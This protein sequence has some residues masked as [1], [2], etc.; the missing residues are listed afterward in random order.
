MSIPTSLQD[1]QAD[2]APLQD[3]QADHASLQDAQ[4]DH[5]SF[6][7]AQADNA[8]TSGSEFDEI[9]DN[10]YEA[11]EDFAISAGLEL[12][13]FLSLSVNAQQA[14]LD[15]LDSRQYE[16]ALDAF[17]YVIGVELN[18]WLRRR[19]R[20]RSNSEQIETFRK[21]VVTSPSLMGSVLPEC[22][23]GTLMRTMLEINP[24]VHVDD[25]DSQAKIDKAV[26]LVLTA[27]FGLDLESIV[28]ALKVDQEHMTGYLKSCSNVIHLMFF[29]LELQQVANQGPYDAPE[30][31]LVA[32]L[33]SQIRVVMRWAMTPDCPGRLTS[34]KHTVHN[35]KT[36]ASKQTW[37]TIHRM[38]LNLLQDL[39]EAHR[40]CQHC[41]QI[42]A[43][44]KVKLCGD[45]SL[46]VYCSA[47]W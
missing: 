5:A 41:K 20:N 14:R 36:T 44:T 29:L 9:S 40:T 32:N 30:I 21:T 11:L 39:Q 35:A 7:D 1:A 13:E 26:N 34:L 27:E 6:P 15:S 38:V 46:A 28:F 42:A 37:I 10:E 25:E 3:A 18:E 4:A 2:H 19:F 17:D 23:E 43:K 22:M 24:H 12:D 8:D 47:T 31:E 45:C 33:I 16:I